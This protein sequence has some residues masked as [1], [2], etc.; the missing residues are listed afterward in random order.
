MTH[1]VFSSGRSS[2]HSVLRS[3]SNRRASTCRVSFLLRLPAGVDCP[4]T[5]LGRSRIMM[6]TRRILTAVSRY[7]L[8]VADAGATGFFGFTIVVRFFRTR[9]SINSG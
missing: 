9:F 7:E 3:Q 2:L 4:V 8:V 5:S 1:I 6:T